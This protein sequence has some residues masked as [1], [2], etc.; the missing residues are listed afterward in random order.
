MSLPLGILVDVFIRSTS[1]ILSQT[2]DP[3]RYFEFNEGSTLCNI[4]RDALKTLIS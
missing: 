2:H 1:D 3:R 4:F